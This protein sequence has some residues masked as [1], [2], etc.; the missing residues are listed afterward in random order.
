MKIASTI[1]A[2]VPVS[3]SG[4]VLNAATKPMP[5]TTPGT[6]YGTINTPSNTA[7]ASDLRRVTR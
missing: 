3:A 4:G 5:I 7:V 1:T 6:T 2:P